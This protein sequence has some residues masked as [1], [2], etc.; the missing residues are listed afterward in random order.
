MYEISHMLG[1]KRGSVL[2][3]FHFPTPLLPPLSPLFTLPCAARLE[4][5]ERGD[6]G[7]AVP[8]LPAGTPGSGHGRG[9]ARLTPLDSAGAHGE[10][11]A[12]LPHGRKGKGER[13]EHGECEHPR[14][15]PGLWGHPGGML[16]GMALGDRG[17][18]VVSQNILQT[19]GWRGLLAEQRVEMV[20]PE[21]PGMFSSQRGFSWL[22]GPAQDPYPGVCPLAR[23]G[24]GFGG[25]S[26]PFPWSCWEE[27]ELSLGFAGRERRGGGRR[28]RAALGRGFGVSRASPVPWGGPGHPMGVPSQGQPF[29][30]AGP[31][32]AHGVRVHQLPRL[33]ALIL[34]SP[35]GVKG[36]EEKRKKKTELGE[37]GSVRGCLRWPGS[38]LG[39]FI[40]TAQA[41]LPE[42]KPDC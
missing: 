9:T 7:A 18:K 27:D 30:T 10:Q 8:Q 40:P 16:V 25:G 35:E 2:L 19:P 1:N 33:P 42:R 28:G 29:F 22:L 4:Q 6:P 24:W 39:V 41:L 13:G 38:V 31:L 23:V 12:L 17:G 3:K 37:S 14:S 5:S 21:P 20:F 36:G 32:G 26:S 34:Q 11:T 15:H